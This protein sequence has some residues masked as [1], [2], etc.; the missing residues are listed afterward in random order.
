VLLRKIAKKRNAWSKVQKSVGIWARQLT[1]PRT[2]QTKEGPI[3]ANPGDW[4]CRG[5]SGEEWPMGNSTL[6]SRYRPTNNINDEGFQ[7]WAPKGDPCFA[8]EIVDGPVDVRSSWGVMTAKSGDYLMKKLEDENEEYPD[9]VWVVD[10]TIFKKTYTRVFS[11]Q[12]IS[13]AFTL[14]TQLEAGK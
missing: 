14:I 6:R 9:D 10:R 1:K 3:D 2:V 8:A 4:L 5:V 11:P 13:V 12:D 7:K